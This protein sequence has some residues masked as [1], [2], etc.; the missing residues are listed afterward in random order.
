MLKDLYKGPSTK[1]E[2]RVQYENGNSLILQLFFYPLY[3]NDFSFM[4]GRRRY[5]YIVK[6]SYDEN[7]K[8][9]YRYDKMGAVTK[10][11]RYVI[12]QKLL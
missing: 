6:G 9:L 5:D 3:N 1:I 4:T 11:L 10:I 12:E 8:L 7:V 2:Y